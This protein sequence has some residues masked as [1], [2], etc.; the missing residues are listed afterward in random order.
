MIHRATSRSQRGMT[1]IEIMVVLAIIAGVMFI[2]RSGFRLMTKA[3]L[4]EDANELTAVMR[5]ASELA[6][7]HGGL[8]RVVLDLDSEGY[9]VEVCQGAIAVARNELV[10]ANDEDTKRALERGRQRLTGLPADAVSM[11]DPE[12]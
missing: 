4:V 9:V 8:H 3:D 11:S 7:E 2:A 5:R 1:L 6:I 12:D 10:R